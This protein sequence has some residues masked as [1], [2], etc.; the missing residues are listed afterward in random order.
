MQLKSPMIR[1]DPREEILSISFSSSPNTSVRKQQE[2]CGGMYVRHTY[3]SFSVFER[4]F[5][6]LNHRKF[7][8]VFY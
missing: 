6:I 3:R 5:L 7:G 8:E 4:C 2:F 1:I